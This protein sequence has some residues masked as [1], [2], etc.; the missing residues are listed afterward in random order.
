MYKLL[1]ITQ[2]LTFPFDP[3]WSEYEATVADDLN[4]ILNFFVQ[5]IIVQWHLH[6]EK[7]P[8]APYTN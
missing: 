8:F 5:K 4:T 7:V 1:H 6:Q 3:S 2:I